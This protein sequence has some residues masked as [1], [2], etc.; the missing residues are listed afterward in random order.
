MLSIAIH[1]CKINS[2]VAEYQPDGKAPVGP[3]AIAVSGSDECLNPKT[4]QMVPYT[5][6]RALET[7]EIPEIAQAFADAAK[8]ALSAG[9]NV[10]FYLLGLDCVISFNSFCSI[11]SLTTCL[12][13]HWLSL[14]N[15]S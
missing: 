3:S 15:P 6:P 9:K 14:L 2:H 11:F 10:H 12:I 1:I 4:F 7:D 5:V 13:S 8:N